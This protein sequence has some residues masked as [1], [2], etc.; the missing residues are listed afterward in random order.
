VS[1]SLFA[2]CLGE[3]TSQNSERIATGEGI[4]V[5]ETQSTMPVKM[6][7]TGLFFLFVAFIWRAIQQQ[8]FCLETKKL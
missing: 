5:T 2:I 3:G 4:A 8:L 7:F 1:F 6:V